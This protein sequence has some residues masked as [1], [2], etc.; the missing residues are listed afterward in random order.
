MIKQWKVEPDWQEPFLAA[1][2]DRGATPA[3][4]DDALGD[5]DDACIRQNKTAREIFGD[6]VAYGKDYPCLL[7]TSPSPRDRTRSRMPSSA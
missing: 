1:L 3:Q 2:A 6:P 5:V 4:R 7:Y